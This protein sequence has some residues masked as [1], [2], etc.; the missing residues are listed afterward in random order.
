MTRIAYTL[1]ILALALCATGAALT[2]ANWLLL[3]V[4]ACTWCHG[5]LRYEDGRLDALGVVR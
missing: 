5:W 2:D 1:N 3:L 4:F